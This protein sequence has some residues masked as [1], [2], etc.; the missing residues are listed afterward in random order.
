MGGNKI[1]AEIIEAG[2]TLRVV[3]KQ[4]GIPYSRLSGICSNW[5]DATP[6]ELGIIRAAIRALSTRRTRQEAGND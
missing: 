1:K 3:S 6:T 4:A 5:I 2:L